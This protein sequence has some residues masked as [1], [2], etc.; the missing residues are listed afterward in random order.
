MLKLVISEQKIV[1]AVEH[2]AKKKIVTT[3]YTI[4][5]QK[6]KAFIQKCW[7]IT[8]IKELAIVFERE[9]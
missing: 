6:T 8:L 3:A 7:I 5:A 1:Q 2:K 9:I 4:L